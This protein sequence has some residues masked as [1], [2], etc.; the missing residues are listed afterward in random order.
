[1]IIPTPDQQ[2]QLARM[3][4]ALGHP[5]RVAILLFLAQRSECFF[6]DI[7]QVLSISKATVSQHLSELKDAGL[8]QGSIEPP[9]V[10]YCINRGNWAVAQHLFAQ[11]FSAASSECG[12]C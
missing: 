7:H 6:G 11:F 1:M 10:R 9:K 12:C 8:I 3:A 4:K 2:Q 5:T